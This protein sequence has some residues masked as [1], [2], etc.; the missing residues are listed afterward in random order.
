[1]GALALLEQIPATI[2]VH[3]AV[4]LLC[5][6]LLVSVL[7]ESHHP[8][9][10]WGCKVWDRLVEEYGARNLGLDLLANDRHSTAA[11]SYCVGGQQTG[12]TTAEYTDVH[13]RAFLALDMRE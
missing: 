3:I 13:S 10:F 12:G 11:L 2:G 9:G 1:G 6:S 8:I 5:V 4:D 7:Y